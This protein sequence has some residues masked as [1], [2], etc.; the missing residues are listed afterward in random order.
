MSNALDAS[1]PRRILCRTKSRFKRIEQE[2]EGALVLIAM[3]ER[4]LGLQIEYK[5]QRGALLVARPGEAPVCTLFRRLT[6]AACEL[7]GVWNCT[8]EESINRPVSEVRKLFEA[9]SPAEKH[10]FFDFVRVWHETDERGEDPGDLLS[11][12]PVSNIEKPR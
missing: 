1:G 6:E 8:L 9:M 11:L 7:A 5:S 12:V 2:R 3:S 4:E 10:Q